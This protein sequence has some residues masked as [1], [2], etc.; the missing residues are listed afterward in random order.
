ML[1]RPVTIELTAQPGLTLAGTRYILV[2][3][4]RLV[5]LPAVGAALHQ[6]VQLGLIPV[7]A[8]PERYRACSLKPCGSGSRWAR[9][10]G[11]RHDA[12]R[13]AVR[14]GQRP[15]AARRRLADIMAADITETT[16]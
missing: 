3:F 8:H 6:I 11:G 7:L 16:G 14:R 5:A 13:G 15:R 12:A 4:P 10:A 1:D 2:E 9:D